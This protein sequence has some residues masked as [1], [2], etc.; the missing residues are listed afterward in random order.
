MIE[1]KRKEGES[2]NAFMYRFTKKVQQSGVLKEAKRK[3]FH[4]RSQNKHARKQSALFR[5][6]KK[7]EITRLKKIGK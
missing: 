5:S 1:I 6:A 2:P 7:T 3:R 4:S